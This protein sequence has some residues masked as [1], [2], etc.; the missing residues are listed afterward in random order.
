M[1]ALAAVADQLELHE[2]AAILLATADGLREEIRAPLEPLEVDTHKELVDSL[3]AQL[4]K[5]AWAKAWTKRRKLKPSEAVTL[6]SQ[7]ERASKR[8]PSLV[9]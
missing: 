5:T 9:S 3:Q 2:R 1:E 8:A 4:G 7:P 6:A